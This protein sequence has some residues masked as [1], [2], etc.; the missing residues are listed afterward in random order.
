[1]RPWSIQLR[2]IRDG[3]KVSGT[4]VA[5]TSTPV[6]AARPEKEPE[7]DGDPEVAMSVS[8]SSML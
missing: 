7:L 3:A 4:M 8:L 1:M 5:A 6:S 2:D